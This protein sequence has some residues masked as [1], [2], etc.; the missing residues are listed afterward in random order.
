MDDH[1]VPD[2]DK[3]S[4]HEGGMGGELGYTVD[5][6]ETREA[7]GGDRERGKTMSWAREKTMLMLLEG[8]WVERD[9]RKMGCMR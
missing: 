2:E 7:R 3:V 5:T 6:Y 1:G 8:Y 4:R 9:G